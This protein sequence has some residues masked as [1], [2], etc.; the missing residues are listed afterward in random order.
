MD[1]TQFKATEVT[2]DEDYHDGQAA[3]PSEPK[4]TGRLT[5]IEDVIAYATAGR[6]KL[7][8]KSTKT[9]ARFT[10]KIKKPHP[11]SYY[12]RSKIA[13]FVELMNGPDNENNFNYLGCINNEQSGMRFV[14]GKK[15]KIG[16]DA[17]SATVFNWFWNHVVA[18]R[19]L[20][21][22]LEV[23]HEGTCCRCGRSLTVPESVRDGIGPECRKKM[24]VL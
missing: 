19:R 17:P 9:E 10:Y 14:H 11:N 23:W 12:S 3:E 18:Q 7:T 21:D 22:G 15:S 16:A 5:T 13:F 4:L 24:G 6:A 20:V 2:D 8:L 1:T